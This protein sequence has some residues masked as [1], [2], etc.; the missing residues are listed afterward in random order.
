MN[1][2]L[3]VFTLFIISQ[4][5]TSQPFTLEEKIQPVELTWEEYKKDDKKAK[6]RV[7]TKA[8]NQD[9]D[10]AYYW[11][12]GISMYSPAFFTITA[13]DPSADLKINLCKE[14]WKQSHQ[15]G[16][17]KGKGKWNTK[18]KT[19]GDFGI[20]VITTKKPVRYALLVWAGDEV[21]V[22]LP[23][24]FKG[25]AAAGG[26]EGWLKK[27]MTLV[28]VVLAALAVIGFLLFKLKRQKK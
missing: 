24:P 11:I 8:C 14:N 16:S 10:T 26:G 18:F 4:K 13:S 6:G 1:K 28:I 3:F 23:S 20:Q 12:Q 5:G 9:T 27:N 2:L 7:S 22:D 19:E 17:I 15:S 25:G 21:K